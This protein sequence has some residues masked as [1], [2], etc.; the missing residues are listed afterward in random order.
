MTQTQTGKGEEKQQKIENSD[1]L[2]SEEVSNTGEATGKKNEDE[3]KFERKNC[4][5]N[6]MQFDVES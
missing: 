3:G 6:E 2:Q 5:K 1:Q 4:W